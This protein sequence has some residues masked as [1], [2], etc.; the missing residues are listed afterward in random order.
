[1]LRAG[2]AL[3]REDLDVGHRRGALGWPGIASLALGCLFCVCLCACTVHLI[4]VGSSMPSSVWGHIGMLWA[5]IITLVGGPQAFFCIFFGI[6]AVSMLT[7]PF[8]FFPSYIDCITTH[9]GPFSPSVLG[10][11]P[12]ALFRSRP[13]LVGLWLVRFVPL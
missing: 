3:K 5:P 12:F 4:D 10:E 2:C 8:Y 13:Q 9:L 6:M 7:I 11:G 1:M